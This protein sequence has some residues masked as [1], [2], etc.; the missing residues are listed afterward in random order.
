MSKRHTSEQPV[1]KQQ[2]DPL[3]PKQ[4]SNVNKPK[5]LDDV[6]NPNSP[7]PAEPTAQRNQIIRQPR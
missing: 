6:R 3:D 5:D 2:P 4:Q 1:E 7:H